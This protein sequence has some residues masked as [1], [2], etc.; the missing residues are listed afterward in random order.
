MTWGTFVVG[1]V[2]L[3]LVCLIVGKMVKDKRAGKSIQ[4]G[5]DCKHCGGHCGD[6]SR[7]ENADKCAGSID[8]AEKER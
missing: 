8:I 3:V 4:C 1:L 7:G 5:G 2:L 6:L